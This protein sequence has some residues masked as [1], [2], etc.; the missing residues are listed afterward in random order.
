MV[1]DC[2]NDNKQKD[3]TTR[4]AFTTHNPYILT[5]L[6]NLL[7]AGEIVKKNPE[8]EEAVNKVV[9]KQHWMTIDKIGAYSIE[10]GL[11]KS[12]IYEDENLI[13]GDYLDS[14]SDRVSEEFSKLL[15][16]KYGN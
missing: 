11:L 5:S 7:L 4:L 13:N 6:N 16:I 9:S 8:K 1:K 10:E 2:F 15:D 14:L 12:A 3:C